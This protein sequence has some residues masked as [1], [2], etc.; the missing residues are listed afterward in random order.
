MKHYF[1]L[2]SD[3]SLTLFGPIHIA[4]ILLT[5]LLILLIYKYRNKLKKFKKIRYI[6]PII[7]LS[8]MVIYIV[9]AIYFKLFDINVHLP[10]HY[11]YITGF[12][13][14]YMLLKEKKNWFNTLY[15][16]IFFCTITVIIFQDPNIT[17]DRYE[18]ILLI[19]SHHFLLISSF[20]T[21]YVLEY[22]V[23]KNGL[24]FKK[25]KDTK[26]RIFEINVTKEQFFKLKEKILYMKD[27][28]DLYKYDFIGII[29]RY[30][31]VP[32]CFKNKYV[33]SQFIAK[34]LEDSSIYKFNKKIYF[35]E[36]K[37]FEKM[38]NVNEIYTGKYLL[39]K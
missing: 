22:P 33:C 10:I 32:I 31:K 26:C 17:Y 28:E 2:E 21:L 30:F 34:L 7:L 5:L 8:N 11:C 36:P 27:N 29:L 4:L 20:Y 14:M 9:G 39:Y 15:Y 16:A 23:D 13:F 35:V 25:F 18:F 37:D 1:G 24:F 19:I 12:A 38:T 3:F 6:I